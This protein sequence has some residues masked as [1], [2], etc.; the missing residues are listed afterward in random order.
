MFPLEGF[1]LQAAPAFASFKTASASSY[2]V[3]LDECQGQ[4]ELR[5]AETRMH[6]KDVAES[7]HRLVVS[8]R[9]VMTDSHFDLVRR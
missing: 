8:T 3:F 6:V 2:S 9:P 1:L 5:V 7:R 4:E